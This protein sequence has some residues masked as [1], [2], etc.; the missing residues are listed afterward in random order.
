MLHEAQG[1]CIHTSR[2]S[3]LLPL[4]LASIICCRKCANSVCRLFSHCG[5]VSHL[6]EPT[7]WLTIV[8]N[9]ILHPDMTAANLLIS[10]DG[11]LR[12]VLGIAL[13]ISFPHRFLSSNKLPH[14]FRVHS[15]PNPDLAKE[16]PRFPG[17]WYVL[18]LSISF[19]HR[20]LFSNKLP[21]PFLV[22]FIALYTVC[23][24]SRSMQIGMK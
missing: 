19:L 3:P 11:T 5:Y 10:N 24:S 15:N 7:K 1:T 6:L 23:A 12:I 20:F 21:H 17:R 14:P 22:Y 4:H 2:S 13:S 16:N 18:T 8:Q 9:H